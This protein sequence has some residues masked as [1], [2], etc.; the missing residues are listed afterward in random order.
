MKFGTLK[1]RI[2][3]PEADLHIIILSD[4]R[5][6]M[7]K[8]SKIRLSFQRMKLRRDL[9]RPAQKVDFGP[10]DQREIRILCE[11][12]AEFY[13]ATLSSKGPQTHK[14]T[15]GEQFLARLPT[16]E[17]EQLAVIFENTD[18]YP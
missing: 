6:W 11:R 5:R 18:D 12:I 10:E 16:P 17:Q 4:G 2:V 3:E 9:G 7:P 8:L 15:D 1:K 14:Q 13:Q